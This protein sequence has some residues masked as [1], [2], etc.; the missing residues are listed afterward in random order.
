VGEF[1]APK[2][3]PN[4]GC[5]LRN[6]PTDCFVLRPALQKDKRKQSL[7]QYDQMSK[8]HTG[9]LWTSDERSAFSRLSF[10]TPLQIAISVSTI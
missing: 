6:R 8:N 10:A 3:I 7:R 9:E 2:T 5:L 1:C 4:D